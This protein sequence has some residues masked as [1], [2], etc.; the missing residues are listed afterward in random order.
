M[1]LNP[2]TFESL[3][4]PPPVILAGPKERANSILY[5]LF[6]VFDQLK[7][8]LSKELNPFAKT[9]ITE[10]SKIETTSDQDKD[11]ASSPIDQASLEKLQ[12]LVAMKTF[13]NK[14]G[15]QKDSSIQQT[16]DLLIEASGLLD[17]EAHTPQVRQIV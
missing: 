15:I 4:M 17:N 10:E 7:T 9:I 1:A 11:Q 12:L 3:L 5:S 8:D 6:G 16:M 13:E 14:Q 2:S